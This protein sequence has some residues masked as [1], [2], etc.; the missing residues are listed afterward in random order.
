VKQQYQKQQVLFLFTFSVT[1]RQNAG[2]NHSLL[3]ANDS[4]SLEQH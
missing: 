1:I 3:T 2:H 4:N